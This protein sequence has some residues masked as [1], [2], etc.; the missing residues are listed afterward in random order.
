M[1]AGH[2]LRKYDPCEWGGTETAVQRLLDGLREHNVENYVF[3]PSL[4][5]PGSEEPLS[6]SCRAIRRFR[7]VVPV[8]NLSAEQRWQLVTLGGNLLSW[9]LG[10]QLWR[11]PGLQIIHAHTLG[12]LGG[13]ARLVARLHGIPFVV[14]IH[15]GVLDLPASVQETLTKPL[16]GGWEWGKA[17]GA[18]VRAR[19]VLNDADAILTVNPR[20]A[21]LL[22]EKFPNKRV[23]VQP[24][25]I[26]AAAGDPRG[27][28]SEHTSLVQPHLR[29]R[30]AH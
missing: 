22:R 7:S 16:E 20:E 19:Q 29:S 3:A 18:L 9:E 2:L 17:F 27:L 14:T 12:R 15:G 30:F 4:E 26:P 25:G 5:Q 24:H 6:Q 8:A 28:G 10:W 23:I 1:V 21:A 11:Q 13:T